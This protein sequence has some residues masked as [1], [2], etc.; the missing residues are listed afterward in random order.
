[1]KSFSLFSSKVEEKEN[2]VSQTTQKDEA[3]LDLDIIKY[4]ITEFPEI[5]VEI[6]ESLRSLT[7]TIEKSIDYIED[8]SND[9]VKQNRDY[10]LGGKYRD[11]SIKLYDISRNIDDYIK[12][13]ES[14]L[15]KM[16]EKKEPVNEEIINVEITDENIDDIS[17][18]KDDTLIK[19]FIY[20]DFTTDNPCK[21]RLEEHEKSVEGWEDL[22]V[23]TAD[24][25]N[26]NYK[27]IKNLKCNYK[28]DNINIAL[29][30]SK[31]ND[32]RDIIIDMLKEHN[33]N[34]ANFNVYIKKGTTK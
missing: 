31:E 10:M 8:K 33:I 25:L 28:D 6:K 22:I 32:S 2:V 4:V 18:D 26:K 15:A 23:K 9:V 30:K 29:R 14:S 3:I 27:H 24:L 19:K 5:A 17:C 7:E 12:W 11:T 13:M 16:K 20:E 21:I 34:L 1:M